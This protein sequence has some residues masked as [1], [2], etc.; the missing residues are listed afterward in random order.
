VQIIGVILLAAGALYFV[1]LFAYGKY[2][3]RGVTVKLAI[4]DSDAE[5]PK[6][7]TAY[8]T[9]IADACPTASAETKWEYAASGFT[10]AQVLR[11][12]VIRL[13][14]VQT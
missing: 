9:L 1:G 12:E 3:D 11:C 10:E 8:M 6:G 2:K 4:K 7:I 5:A 14:K 13:G